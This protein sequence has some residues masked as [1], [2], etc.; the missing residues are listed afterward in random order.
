M[1]EYLALAH[2]AAR[3]DPVLGTV[4]AAPADALASVD[5]RPVTA[6]AAPGLALAAFDTDPA[7]RADVAAVLASAT[8]ALVDAA[9]VRSLLGVDVTGLTAQAAAWAICTQLADP[10]GQARLRPVEGAPLQLRLASYS[11]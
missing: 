10:T 6:Q 11:T 1:T 5:L 3:T 4:Y 7:G 8:D 2:I 9:A